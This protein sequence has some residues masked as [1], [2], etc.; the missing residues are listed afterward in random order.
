M[1]LRGPAGRL[2]F[3][4]DPYYAGVIS[5]ITAGTRHISIVGSIRLGGGSSAVSGKASDLTKVMA[6]GRPPQ[7]QLFNLSDKYMKLLGPW[8]ADHPEKPAKRDRF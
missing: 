1:N 2:L 5:T 7:A 3:A 6:P 4:G 8:I